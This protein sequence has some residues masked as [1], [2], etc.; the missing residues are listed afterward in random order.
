[1]IVAA[2]AGSLGLAGCAGMVSSTTGAAEIATMSGSVHGGQQPVAGA[3]VSLIAPGTSGYGSA[4]TVIVSTTTDANGNF[5]LPQPYTCPAN[6]GLVYLL[7]TGGNAGAGTNPAIAEAAILGPCSSLTPATYVSIS[8]VTTVAAAYALAPF[9]TVSATGTNIGTSA[10][11]LQGLTNA[12]GGAGNLANIKTG[13]AH[14]TGDFPGIVPPTSELNTIAD[15]LSSCVNQG[16]SALTAGTCPKLFTAT[17]PTG[18]VAPIDTFQAALNIALHPASNIFLL[19]QLATPNAPYQP[20]LSAAP[21]DFS[22]A[23]GFNGGAITSGA[24]TVGVAIDALGDAW[25]TTGVPGTGVHVLTEISPSGSY[26]SGSTVGATTGYDS[27]ALN[28]SVGLAIDQSGAIYV[29]NNGANNLVKFNPNATVQSTI[30]ATSFNFVNGVAIDGAGDP[31]IANFGGNKVTEINTSGVEA[32]HSPFTVGTGGVDITAGPKAIWE[33]DYGSNYISRIDLTSNA[34]TAYTIGG[35][36][37]GIAL[38]HN[39]TAWIAVTGNGS[40][41]EV[42]DAGAF[43]SPFGGYQADPTTNPQNIIVDGLGNVFAGTYITTGTSM[44]SLLEYSNGG[45]LLSP[46]TGYIGSSVIPVVP[47]VPG[48]IGIDGSG[49]V[50]I[51]GT[52][53]GTALPNYVAEI[54]GIAAP[55][56][57]PR[58]VAA[59]NNTVGVRP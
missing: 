1:M 13:A 55:V 12:A 16:T 49:N 6:S 40:V 59:T 17:T 26:L 53:N 42:T 46:S 54:V 45:T 4:G 34:V 27:S 39:N 22:V 38:D 3:T 28:N 32:T 57:T 14:V 29:A 50:W 30:T 31:W 52:N 36:T 51:A 43:L 25:L 21:S 58:S 19:F 33:T 44:G 23:L 20:T 7:A 37:G 47:E 11:N 41:F 35:T 9:A 10:T 18:G 15:I 56:V 24:G 2:F 5:T 48:G 8:E